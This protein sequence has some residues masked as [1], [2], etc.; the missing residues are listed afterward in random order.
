MKRV[1]QTWAGAIF[2]CVV[3]LC[4]C[5]TPGK[6]STD[7]PNPTTLFAKYELR[8]RAEGLLM[9]G[10]KSDLDIIAANSIEALQRVA[11][12]AAKSTFSIALESESPLVR[13]AACSAIGMT[14]DRSALDRVRRKLRDPDPRV[15]LA[16]SF[17]AARLGDASQIK[18][19]IA[20]LNKNPDANLRADAAYFLGSLGDPRAKQQLLAAQKQRINEQAN[21]VLLHI[22]G[23]LAKLG[24]RDALQELIAYTQ[25]DAVSKVL[26]LQMLAEI[27]APES[28][29]AL[30]IILTR[31]DE[32]Y[33]ENRLLAA[34]GL[35]KI[36]VRDGT[37]LALSNLNY[38]GKNPDDF[39]EEAR[40]RSLAALALG[41]IRAAK[42]LPGLKDLAAN[43]TDE[44]VQVAA[45]YA[46]CL[47][48]GE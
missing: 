41:E 1:K 12:R 3:A 38:A 25:G 6:D 15:R 35:G 37:D 24:D 7:G 32:E 8:D 29:P 20:V 2:C 21:R 46:I 14:R 40:I 44:R 22:T 10:A 39:S 4:G 9:A 45:A 33:L 23:A 36:G 47:I 48:V 34:R 11:P 19:L 27:G 17:A 30:Q 13:F 5:Q 26:S 31:G 28:R 43:S 18:A 42:A 16:A